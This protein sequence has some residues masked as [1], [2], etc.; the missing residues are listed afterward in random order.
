LERTAADR[1]RID[2]MT[3][4]VQESLRRMDMDADV[5]RQKLD[6]LAAARPE[7]QRVRRAALRA[8]WG[9]VLAHPTAREELTTHGRRMA[10]LRRLQYL[11][12]TERQGQT[13]TKLLSRIDTLLSREQARHERAMKSLEENS[14]AERT[15]RGEPSS[16]PAPSPAPSGVNR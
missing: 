7:R 4:E 9:K 2:T 10:R 1:E 15:S 12:A 5:L 11:A 13:R 3:R 14:G 8:K 6:A 16:L